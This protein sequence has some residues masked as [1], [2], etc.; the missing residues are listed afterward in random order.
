MRQFFVLPTA[1]LAA[2]PTPGAWH[3]IQTPGR[4]DVSV[5]VVEHW[6]SHAEQDAWEALPGVTEHPI[7]NWGAVVPPAMVTAFGPWGV[8]ATDTIAGAMR[9]IRAQWPEA[10][11]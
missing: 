6:R 3:A 9:K 11:P 2:N 4:P 8:L 7:W 10:R 5:V 1:T